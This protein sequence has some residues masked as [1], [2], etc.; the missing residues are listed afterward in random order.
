MKKIEV[1]DKR[2]SA[3]RKFKHALRVFDNDSGWELGYVG[4]VTTE[5][6]LIVGNVG[7][8]VGSR[9]RLRLEIPLQGGGTEDFMLEAES[10][11]IQQD[12]ESDAWLTGFSC[13]DATRKCKVILAFLIRGDTS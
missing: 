8:E 10:K 2:Q 13:E 4:D 6:I 11:W 5:G 9:H 7:I 1:T 12:P 3:R